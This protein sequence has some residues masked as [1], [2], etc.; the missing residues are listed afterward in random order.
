MRQAAIHFGPSLNEMSDDMSANRNPRDQ[1]ASPR[2]SRN[3]PIGRVNVDVAGL[4]IHTSNVSRNGAQLVCPAMR[5]PA[6]QPLLANPS[7]TLNIALPTGREIGV[8]ARVCYA[9]PCADEYLIG[10]EFISFQDTD[11]AG[12]FAY[13][14]WINSPRLRGQ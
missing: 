5:F 13:I 10:V 14:D 6:L 1:R 3:L 7:V 9:C 12:W 4:I 8:S 11:A 2:V